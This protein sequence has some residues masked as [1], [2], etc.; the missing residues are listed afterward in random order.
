MGDL[1]SGPKTETTSNEKF[2]SGPSSF[3]KPYLTDVFDKAQSVFGSK[4]GTPYY[5]GDTYAGMTDEQKATYGDMSKYAN[6]AGIGNAGAVS[7]F[8]QNAMATGQA[9]NVTNLDRFTSLASGDGT[10][11]NIAAATKYADNPYVDGMIDANSR[12]VTR[13]LYEDQL[14]GI[15]R[16]AAGSGNINSSRTGIAAGIAER[17]AADRIGDIS[18]SIRHDAYSSG[19][20]RAQADRGMQLDAYGKAA[21]A[22]GRM[23]GQGLGAAGQGAGMAYDALGNAINVQDAYQDDAQGEMDAAFAA[24]QGQDTRDM[25]MLARYNSIVGGNQWGQSG[26]SSGTGTS[27]QSGGLGTQILGMGAQ[28][29]AAYFGSDRRLKQNIVLIGSYADGLGIYVYQYRQDIS[30]EHGLRLPFGLQIGVMA[31]EVERLRPHALGP[32]LDGGYASVNYAAL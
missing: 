2:D 31:D 5:E 8:G 10:A 12:D 13:N 19:L 21:D 3:Q 9:G 20:D 1:F 16:A 30:D 22:Y 18:A 7:N 32:V 6:G 11:A 29:A 24:W 27:Q 17:G 4:L 28:A 14:P 15:D 23:A 25:D 26:T